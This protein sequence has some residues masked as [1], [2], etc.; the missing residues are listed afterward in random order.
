M[1]MHGCTQRRERERERERG[2]EGDGG[3]DADADGDDGGVSRESD[4]G[5]T[6]N[7]RP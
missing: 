7:L 5:S 3:D 2:R 1:S 6:P 4:F